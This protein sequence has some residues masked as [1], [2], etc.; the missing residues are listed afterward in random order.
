MQTENRILHGEVYNL[1]IPQ[2]TSIQEAQFDLI[3]E[4]TTYNEDKGGYPFIL[5]MMFDD[6]SEAFDRFYNCCVERAKR[7]AR[8]R[9]QTL[10]EQKTNEPSY[11]QRICFVHY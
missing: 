8:Q 2:D 11:Q 4:F 10:L 5:D 1:G 3:A 6:G 9:A 7:E